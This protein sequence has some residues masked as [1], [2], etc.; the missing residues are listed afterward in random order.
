MKLYKYII[1]TCNSYKY[2]EKAMYLVFN[3]IKYF[4]NCTPLHFIKLSINEFILGY[5]ICEI[6]MYNMSQRFTTFHNCNSV[7]FLSKCALLSR[8]ASRQDCTNL[9]LLHYD[10]GNMTCVV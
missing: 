2:V 9:R 4:M 5:Y 3:T 6:E 7:D 1:M 8:E 10:D